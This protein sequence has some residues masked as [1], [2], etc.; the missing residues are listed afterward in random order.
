M[1]IESAPHGRLALS[2]QKVNIT[3]TPEEVPEMSELTRRG[4]M[5]STTSAVTAIALAAGLVVSCSTAPSTTT[6][7]D[8]LTRKAMAERQEWNKVDPGVE[9]FVKKSYGVAIFPEVTKGGLGIGGAYGRGLVY[10]QGEQI[11]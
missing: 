8:E 3:S 1:S 6:E 11:G 2:S 9:A 4:T 7:R 5:T 10:E